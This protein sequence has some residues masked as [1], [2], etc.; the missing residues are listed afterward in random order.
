MVSVDQNW[1]Q[2]ANSE[3][4]SNQNANCRWEAD[5][6]VDL[7][8]SIWMRCLQKHSSP[9]PQTVPND[10]LS[11]NHTTGWISWELL[12]DN[13]RIFMKKCE[14]HRIGA[15]KIELRRWLYIAIITRTFQ[16]FVLIHQIDV[17]LWYFL[18]IRNSSQHQLTALI[19]YW[20]L[21][22]PCLW[23]SAR[24]KYATC[25]WYIICLT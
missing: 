15:P 13:I 23:F 11:E 4:I 2:L 16:L 17:L 14:I 5:V 1:Q 10:H 7:G 12:R 20:H 18:L 6:E 19:I 25:E 8:D 9:V 24:Y 22:N 3:N 21:L